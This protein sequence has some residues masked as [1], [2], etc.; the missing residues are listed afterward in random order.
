MKRV[1]LLMLFGIF[2]IAYSQD[3]DKSIEK[4]IISG[5]IISAIT[6]RPLQGITVKIEET[7][8]GAISNLDG[9][10]S[11]KNVPVGI[12]AVKFT[13][14]GYATYIQSNVV[15]SAV[16]PAQLEI[17]L[18]EKMF[19]V[20]EVEVKASYFLRR[21][22]TSSSSQTLSSEDIRRTP[23][24][25]EDVVRA[26]AL[27]P[28]VGVTSSGRNDLLVRGGAP[29]ENLFLVD[30]IEV[31]NINHF[32]TQGSTGGPLSIINIDF[33]KN[34]NFSSGAFGAKYGDKTSSITNITL[35]NGN[36]E[37]FG[38]K[39]VLSATGFGFHLEG[40]VAE[41]SSYFFSVR[42]SYLDFIFKAAGFAFIP[43]YWDFQGKLNY[44]INDNNYISFLTIGALGTVKLN[45]DDNDKIYDNSRVAVPNQN[46]YFSGITWKHLFDS[47]Y[48]TVT[49]GET[50]T[51]YSTYQNSNENPP[52][53]IFNNN[54]TEAETSL[55]TDVEIQLAPKV[56]L[57]FGNQV[58]WATRL[59]YDILVPGFLRKDNYGIEQP[60]SIDTN[61]RAYKNSSYISLTSSIDKFKFT[62]GGRSDYYNFLE[63]KWYFSPRA[64]IIYQLNDVS[65]FVISGGR[66]FQSPSYIWLIGDAQNKNM[67]PIQ[68]DQIVIGYD[69]TP[70]E[71]LKVQLEAFYKN[72]SNYPGRVFRPQAVLA[73]SGFEDFTS[74]IPFGL[75]PINSSAEGHSYGVELFIQKKLSSI[76]LY[77]LF[78]L[79][80]AQSKFKSLD[81]IERYGAYD[82]RIIMNLAVGYRI[83]DEWEI[84]SKFR[85]AT[86]Q[87]TTPF[88][89]SGVKDFQN[90][91]LGDRLPLFHT[92]DIRVD[93]RW[94]FS[95][96][97]LVTYFDIQNLY[98]RKNVSGFRWNYQENRVEEQKSFGILPTIGISLEF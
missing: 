44:K 93:K 80:F 34:V 59:Q 11:V 64:S 55:R 77:G 51:K 74:D 10:F 75:E 40:P 98:S 71:D 57:Y 53:K 46:Q 45:N 68:S 35:R 63:T 36:E 60:L 17:E 18:N 24:V 37:N 69:H 5:R 13:A 95:N 23:G 87:P 7:K 70:M 22:E 47:G 1:I 29:Y 12:Y 52:Q 88:T 26:T 92:L 50:Y 42:R 61:F 20:G 76:P 19:E 38:G 49:L 6:Q 21:I 86:G 31:P 96:L 9:Y 89:T 67:S 81:G 72:Y 39:A 32:G 97:Y 62:L 28:G 41:G 78:S 3:S 83:D 84:S 66:Y 58:K 25:Q 14:V 79:T 56:D 30:N 94:N 33:V 4:G 54:S 85:L 8:L 65:A 2:N 15:V 16:K 27:L 48:L 82:S 73:P 43:E 91:N 90:Y